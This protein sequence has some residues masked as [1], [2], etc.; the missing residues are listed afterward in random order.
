MLYPFP[1]R[2][3]QELL[4]AYPDLREVIWLQEEPANMGAWRY[5]HGPLR[6]LTAARGVT[7]RAVARPERASPAPGTATMHSLEQRN[8]IEAVLRG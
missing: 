2:E 6:E 1:T 7:L 8:L 3:L 5:L 4:A